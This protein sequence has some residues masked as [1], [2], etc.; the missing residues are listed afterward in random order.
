TTALATLR[1]LATVAVGATLAAAALASGLLLGGGRWLLGFGVLC[2]ITGEHAHQRLDQRLDQARL[3]LLDGAIGCCN[4]RW[5]GSRGR[6]GRC[7][8]LDRCLLTHD[9]A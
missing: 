5:S 2:L 9:S 6:A 4:G 3:G 8:A 7:D 1:P